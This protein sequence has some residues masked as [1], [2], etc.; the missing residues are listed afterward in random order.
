MR[1]LGYDRDPREGNR[2]SDSSR[3]F[4]CRSRRRMEV[5]EIRK[6]REVV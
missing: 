6:D 3:G 1:L 2:V 4:L 5:M